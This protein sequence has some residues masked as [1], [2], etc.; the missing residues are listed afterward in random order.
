MA[1]VATTAALATPAFRRLWLAELLAQTAQNALWFAALIATERATHSTALTGV[2][3]VSA[4]IPVALVGLPAGV[5]VDRWDK[6]AVL[7]WSSL[8]RVALAAGYLG[9]GWSIGVS[10][11][12]IHPDGFGWIMSQ[13]RPREPGQVRVAGHV[14]IP[15]SPDTLLAP[16][17]YR[18]Q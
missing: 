11:L 9:Y 18:T 6:Q 17:R 8:L 12:I 7:V 16:P 15:A 5:L 4:T 2:T 3:V 10:W 13:D 1:E 14:A